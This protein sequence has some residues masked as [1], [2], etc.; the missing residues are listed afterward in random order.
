M[1]YGD[2]NIWQQQQS[3]DLPSTGGGKRNAVI[4]TPITYYSDVVIQLVRIFRCQCG[5]AMWNRYFG[6]IQIQFH[7]SLCCCQ[8]AKINRGGITSRN[9]GWYRVGHYS[10]LSTT[11]CRC[12]C[13]EYTNPR[14]EGIFQWNVWWENHIGLRPL[15]TEIVSTTLDQISREATK[16]TKINIA[17]S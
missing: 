5:E 13:F 11:R 1:L 3:V 6:H 2:E 17:T 4:N 12:I 16:L 9:T 14:G 7:T 8:G 10:S 15:L